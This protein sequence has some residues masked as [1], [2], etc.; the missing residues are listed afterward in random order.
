[1][2]L[3]L[4]ISITSLPYFLSLLP[5]LLFSLFF[6]AVALDQG[7]KAIDDDGILGAFV[8]TLIHDHNTLYYQYGKAN[9]ECNVHLIRYL[10]ANSGNTHHHWSDDMIEFLFKVFANLMTVIKTAIKQNISPL[11]AIR[12]VFSGSCLLV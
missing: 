6:N 9:G 11:L 2:F 12:S 5:F 10:E 8:N 1:M 3:F 7:E 4:H